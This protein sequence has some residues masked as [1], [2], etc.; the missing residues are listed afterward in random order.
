M[1]VRKFKSKTTGHNDVFG[2]PVNHCLVR[3]MASFLT[4]LAALGINRAGPRRNNHTPVQ[5]RTIR[6]QEPEG[7][8]Q[9]R[10]LRHAFGG[11]LLRL[12]SADGQPAA[13][14][15]TGLN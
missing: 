10:L 7:G 12:L 8:N 11:V 2:G 9:A 3:G 1:F 15:T 14:A 4:A 13:A 6:K 5:S